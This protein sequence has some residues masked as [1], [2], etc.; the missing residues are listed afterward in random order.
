VYG[1]R[2]STLDPET[3][4]RP[5]S[6]IGNAGNARQLVQRLKY[7]DETR[8]Y[9]YTRIQGLL[10]GN[11]PWSSKKLVDLGQGHRANFNLREGEGIVDS[12]KTPYYDL[13]FEVP[14]FA[15]IIIHLDGVEAHI[16]RE[17]SDI[18]QEEYYE[19]L[20]NWDGFDQQIQLHQWQMIVNG[21][22]PMF[23]PHALSWRSQATKARKVLVPQETFANVEEL[24]LC[25]VLH[26]WRADELE[27]YISG[28]GDE[29]E[30]GGWNVPLCKQAII[31]SALRE[32]R[33]EW[34]IENYDLYQRAIRTGD[35]FYGIH[36]STRIYVASL[37]VK[38]FG[39]KVSHYIITDSAAGHQQESFDSQE[40]EKGYL[41]KRKGKFD[42]FGQVICPFFYDT[43]PDGTWHSVKGLGPKIYDFCDV[44]NRTFC[45]MLDGS[46]I[47]S[48]IT[49][50]AQE[51]STLEETQIAL[52]GGATVVQPGY[53][54][55]QTRIAESLQG[56]LTMRKEL[57][58]TLQ[59]NTGTYRQRPVEEQR[60]EP[61]YGQAQLNVQQQSLLT[62]G[63]VNRYY[64]GFDRWHR[65]TLRR[66][67]DEAQNDRVP[68]GREAKF[69]VERC[70]MR[71]IPPQVLN[72]R[73]IRKVT[74]TR[75][76]GYGS[77]Q[78]RDMAT[79][80]LIQLIPQMDEV[81]RN[82]ALRARASA[83][84][85]IGPSQVD[86][87]FPPI[88]KRGVPNAHTALA[89]LENNILRQPKA[90]V[91]VD[92][93][94]NHSIHSEEHLKDL[95][96]H[97]QEGQSNPFEKLV[98]GRQALPHVTRHLALLQGDPTRKEEI[99]QKQRAVTDL[100]KET[101]RLQQN[102]EEMMQAA[103]RRQASQQ[104]GQGAGPQQAPDPDMVAKMAK[105]KGDLAL[106]AQK[107]QGDMA[108]K[109][110]KAQVSERLQDQRVAADIKRQTRRSKIQEAQD[111]RD[112][113]RVP[114][115]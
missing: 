88:E 98:H 48:G 89:V 43:G 35:L 82:H 41:Y 21:V 25:V 12:A 72:F 15:N 61:T 101:D 66:L 26:S 11:P 4:E 86:M 27:S 37:F 51:G 14:Y 3:G 20:C 30:F 10:D 62:K 17:W 29:T 31:D 90:Q 64:N 19:T 67:L 96:A 76:V 13:I 63:A 49:L 112:N 87:F 95:S 16:V 92:P 94:Q 77:P 60:P 91:A 59:S 33:Q 2:L 65:E 52:V 106:K 93:Q 53:K 99:K 54:V 36:R 24:E 45:Q 110:R 73:N 80:E 68:G 8:M 40:E 46:V 50:E 113:R 70:V 108:L 111:L 34:G 57:Q 97:Y 79:R 22:G 58:N 39:G 107:A 38:E 7:E 83:L 102:V 81:S 109:V 85:G 78:L 1:Q 105:I 32:M 55:V 9:R 69:F 23:W 84:P 42:S 56:A 71:G 74:A 114:P 47:G 6:R 28:A 104:N 75:S 18:I 100:S 103:A 5:S 44:S 115:A